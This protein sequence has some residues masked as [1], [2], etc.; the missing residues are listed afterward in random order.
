LYF[1]TCMSIQGFRVFFDCVVNCVVP[2][3]T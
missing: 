1:S 2:P 3:F